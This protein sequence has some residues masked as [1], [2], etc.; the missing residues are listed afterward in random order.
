MYYNED[1]LRK[2]LLFLFVLVSAALSSPKTVFADRMI[3]SVSLNGSSS[4]SVAPSALITASVNVTT[5]TLNDKNWRSTSWNI[6]GSNCVNH[7]DYNGA[8]T[9]SE[10]F[11]VTA[12]SSYGTYNISFVAY[13][14]SN[15]SV[16][17]SPTYTL[18]GGI[19]VPSLLGPTPTPTPIRG[20]T[21]APAP[22]DTTISSGP[23][24]YPSVSLSRSNL[25]FSGSASIEQGEINQIE[26]SFDGVNWNYAS[27]NDG[28][29]D[30]NFEYFTFIP[31]QP[32][33]IG[34]YTVVV[35]AKSLAQITTQAQNYAKMT[36]TVSRPKVSLDKIFPKV[37]SN[38]TPTITG[39]ASSKFTK[40]SNVQ[41]SLD[42]GET[43]FLTKLVGNKFSLTTKPLEDGN[44][45]VV[46]RAYDNFGNLGISEKA[47]LII[48]TMPPIIGGEVFSAGAIYLS[49]DNNGDIY[50][51][52]GT[53]IN[54]T[55]SLR[56]GVTSGF[57]QSGDLKFPLINIPKTNIW[58][59]NLIYEQGAS[60]LPSVEVV[61]GAGNKSSRRLNNIVVEKSGS[62]Y[63]ESKGS[64]FPLVGAGIYL[65]YFDTISRSWVLWEGSSF[66][67]DNP[68]VT[69]DSGKYSFIIPPGKY[70]L[71][72]KKDGYKT[73][74][75][76]IFER[77][78]NILVNF[79]FPLSPKTKISL[80]LPIIGEIAFTLPNVNPIKTYEVKFQ[81]KAEEIRSDGRLGKPAPDI[82]I[83]PEKGE[84]VSIPL[85][86]KYVLS[87]VS[88][89]SKTSQEQIPILSEFNRKL[90]DD[91]KLLVI[92]LQD[93]SSSSEV[94]IK[95]GNYIFDYLADKNG[96]LMKNYPVNTLPQHFFI[97]S[98][99]I[100]QDIQ[101]G[102][103]SETELL[104]KMSKLD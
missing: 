13:A 1:V 51:V 14:D 75:S 81:K 20:P 36:F 32:F 31:K 85:R 19:I 103:L 27:P 21:T 39:I 87:F 63:E 76:Q 70:Y 69:T 90:S 68:Q 80:R 15:C 84:S 64:D 43:W 61:D 89:W 17:A 93:T 62:I 92:F 101:N 86:G 18:T 26:Y 44:Y 37:T 73:I 22:T 52:S 9:Y 34:T 3:N 48:D 12:P 104:E 96:E 30:D 4:A 7:V 8:G 49:P 10:N 56:G 95:R 2:L 57:I 35:R 24:Y 72:V 28:K 54:L 83:T 29:F 74:R 97:N 6:T 25:T 42:R 45:D 102:V 47:T 77:D 55:L 40:I 78:E 88:T 58:T 100:I 65:Y 66:G 94:F 38:Q 41:I 71:E 33:T 23:I 60:E 82:K 59:A 99:G 91:E 79:N 50:T 98:S 5:N 11:T 67:Q 53:K 46:A 16:D